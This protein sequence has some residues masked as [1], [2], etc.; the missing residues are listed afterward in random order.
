[1]AIACGPPHVKGPMIQWQCPLRRLAMTINMCTMCWQA[2]SAA[3]PLLVLLYWAISHSPECLAGCAL[4]ILHGRSLGPSPFQT[5]ELVT[6]Q[7]HP[8]P[9]LIESS[10]AQCGPILCFGWIGLSLSS[11][12]AAYATCTTASRGTRACDRKFVMQPKCGQATLH[13]H[14]GSEAGEDFVPAA[15]GAASTS[16]AHGKNT[17]VLP[18]PEKHASLPD[19]SP[20][21]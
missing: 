2:V 13:A 4:T 10:R 3:G 17:K 11:P 16:P 19:D 14:T 15:R 9:G 5:N 8:I 21:C 12:A 20:I 7:A 1:M 18:S 6:F